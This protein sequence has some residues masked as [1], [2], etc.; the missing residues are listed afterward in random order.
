VE[1]QL[2]VVAIFGNGYL[3]AV[4]AVRVLFYVITGIGGSQQTSQ[5]EKLNSVGK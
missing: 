5:S 1:Q 3:L 4:P 2:F